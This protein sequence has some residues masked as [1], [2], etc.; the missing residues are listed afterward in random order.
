MKNVLLC[1]ALLV[2]LAGCASTPKLDQQSGQS[3]V[4]IDPAVV[5][6]TEM[7]FYGPGS[8]FGALGG[9][10]G[11]LITAEANKGPG[12]QLRQFAQDNGI[13]IDQIVRE[14]ATKAFRD[15]GKLHLTDNA[16]ANTATMKLSIYRYGFMTT[17]GFDSDLTPML[18]LTCELVGPDGKTIWAAKNIVLPSDGVVKGST[19]DEFR[20]N[21]KLIEAAW[22]A[23][24][25]SVM[26]QIVD[27]M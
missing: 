27:R 24:A 16:G 6:A 13:L 1:V 19:P 8:A 4:R 26:K 17:S 25:K 7:Y 10:I 21:P 22:R 12:E 18:G 2:T 23:A 15:S 3:D 14:E 5:T 9:A 20:A 11:G